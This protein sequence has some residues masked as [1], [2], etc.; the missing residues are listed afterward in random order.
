MGAGGKIQVRVV[1]GSA[2][3]VKLQ[4]IGA[5]TGVGG[6]V[7]LGVMVTGALTGSG[8]MGDGRRRAMGQN[9]RRRIQTEFPIDMMVRRYELLYRRVF[10]QRFARIRLAA[11]Q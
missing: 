4:G 6:C 7:R 5:A 11:A 8:G 10:S 1:V 9:A 2:Q 3:V